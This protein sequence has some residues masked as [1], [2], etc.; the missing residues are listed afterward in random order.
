MP[1]NTI[2]Q[3][4]VFPVSGDMIVSL[5]NPDMSLDFTDPEKNYSTKNQVVESFSLGTTVNTSDL[6][7]GNSNY[8]R[9]KYTKTLD[10]SFAV[11]L[12][13]YDPKLHAMI[14]GGKF[15]K[16][17]TDVV[18][19]DVKQFQ[20]PTESPFEV[21]LP[22]GVDANT[23]SVK[24]AYGNGLTRATGETPEATDGV[25]TVSATGGTVKLTFAEANKGY[26]IE[27]IFAAKYAKGMSSKMG[28]TVKLPTLHVRVHGV[29]TDVDETQRLMTNY[30][31]DRACVNGEIKPPDLTND[32]T[33]GWT[34][35]LAMLEPRDGHD[36]FS[37][38]FVPIE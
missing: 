9:K 7:S 16:N 6:P 24:D 13:A 28:K 30:V 29:A 21:T 14:S 27:V 18:M 8:V 36:P 22:S 31:I 2:K 38:Y 12:N 15:N 19:W 25:Y 34:I 3:D 5:F 37:Q 33:G 4:L 11:K 32:P 35:N 23:V 17:D 26:N 20:V 1:Q 10:G